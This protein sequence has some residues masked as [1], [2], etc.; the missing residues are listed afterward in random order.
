VEHNP[1]FRSGPLAVLLA[2]AGPS[3]VLDESGAGLAAAICPQ[4]AL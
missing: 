3:A 4:N 1:I 2:D